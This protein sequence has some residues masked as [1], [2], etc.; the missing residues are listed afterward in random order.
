MCIGDYMQTIEMRTGMNKGG[1][2]IIK[3]NEVPKMLGK[4]TESINATIA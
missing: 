3:L 4:Q 1:F 2:Y